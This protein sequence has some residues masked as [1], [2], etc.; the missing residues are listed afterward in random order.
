[1][2][3]KQ[4]FEDFFADPAKDEEKVDTDKI[5][6]TADKQVVVSQDV[7]VPKDTKLQDS[8]HIPSDSEAHMKQLREAIL[9]HQYSDN[10]VVN[11]MF[12]ADKTH[13]LVVVKQSLDVETIRKYLPLD[14]HWILYHKDWPEQLRKLCGIKVTPRYIV[15]VMEV[16]KDEFGFRRLGKTLS[17]EVRREYPQDYLDLFDFPTIDDNRAK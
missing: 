7:S 12:N 5:K 15:S 17:N 4:L 13:I 10:E 2:K 1:M 9:E 3:F 16:T 14:K 11:Q 6:E 8:S